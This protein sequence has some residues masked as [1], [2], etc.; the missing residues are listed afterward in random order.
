[1]PCCVGLYVGWG[2]GRGVGRSVG[3]GV[4]QGVWGFDEPIIRQP[5]IERLCE[6]DA[7]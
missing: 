4:G 5:P 7:E 1:M 2:V 3:R 6:Q